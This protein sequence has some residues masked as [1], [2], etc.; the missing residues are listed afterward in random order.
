GARGSPSWDRS[1]DRM[2]A[3]AFAAAAVVLAGRGDEDK[4]LAEARRRLAVPGPA[5]EKAGKGRWRADWDEAADEA[6]RRNCP[7]LIVDSVDHCVGLESVESTIYAKPA[8]AEMCRDVVLL[9]ALEGNTHKSALREAGGEKVEWCSRFDVPCDEHRKLHQF[10]KERFISREFW[11]PLHLFLD[12]E[13][14]EL[15]RTEGSEIDQ[16]RLER[17][18]GKG[19]RRLGAALGLGDYTALMKKLKGIVDGREKNGAAA[20]D[21]ELGQLLTAQERATADPARGPLRTRGMVDYVNQLRDRIAAAGDAQV[22]V[23]QAKVRG[24]DVAA[25]RALLDQTARSFRDLPAGKLARE[26]LAKIKE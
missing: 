12:A 15:G 22:K 14:N 23:A 2:A 20:A 16:A 11:N 24:G 18:L 17:E 8:F 5:A 6:R 26:Q 10:V 25:A 7:V 19:R 4:A 1:M 21:S 3:I 9:I 13:G